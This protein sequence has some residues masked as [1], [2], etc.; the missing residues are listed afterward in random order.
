MTEEIINQQEDEDGYRSNQLD[1]APDE[2]DMN[3]NKNMWII[4]GYRIW[5]DT[6]QQALE[7]LPLIERL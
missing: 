7:L 5:A 1:P 6:Y 3:T 2:I 4:N